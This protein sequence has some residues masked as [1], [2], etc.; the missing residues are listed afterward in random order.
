[1]GSGRSQRCFHWPIRAAAAESSWSSYRRRRPSLQGNLQIAEAAVN[2]AN[3]PKQGNQ[4][5]SHGS[6]PV[7]IVTN[8]RRN[9]NEVMACRGEF[10]R[11]AWLTTRKRVRRLTHG[12]C[13]VRS[14]RQ[15]TFQVRP[16]LIRR[17]VA[18]PLLRQGATLQHAVERCDRRLEVKAGAG[19]LVGI[20]D[21]DGRLRHVVQV[22]WS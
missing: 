4:S 11:A 9:S 3:R 8:S 19:G 5:L 12:R 14:G 22:D 6:I 16:R 20:G 17:I 18:E 10:A 1:M 13:A 7:A 15:A 21:D 2:R